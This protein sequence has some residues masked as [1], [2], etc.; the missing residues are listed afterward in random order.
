[1]VTASGLIFRAPAGLAAGKYTVI[2]EQSGGR[3]ELGIIGI[4]EAELPVTGLKIPYAVE[5]GKQFVIEGVG[6]D[7][8]HVI[9][10]VRDGES[11]VLKHETVSSGVKVMI[12][13]SVDCGEYLLYLSDGLFY[14]SQA[15]VY[16]MA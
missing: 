3:Q 15:T 4:L 16:I 5:P 8:G 1:M 13:Q 14:L 10:L 7:T 12:P 11:V 6:F 9:S 2:V